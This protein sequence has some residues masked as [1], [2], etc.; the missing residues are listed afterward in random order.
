MDLQMKL[1]RA[2]VVAGTAVANFLDRMFI[3]P[4]CWL[5]LAVLNLLGGLVEDDR[6]WALGSIS[7][8]GVCL[9]VATIMQLRKEG[10]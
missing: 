5:T 3:S 9:V 1:R 7:L 6:A 2:F 8:A 4:G 10:R